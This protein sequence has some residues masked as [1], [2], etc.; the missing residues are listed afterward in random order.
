VEGCLKNNWD[1]LGIDNFAT[2]QK[3]MAD[4][5]RVKHLGGKYSF[6]EADIN[7][8]ERMIKLFVGRDV[9]FHLAALPR[10]SFSVEH[11]LEAHE[12]NATGT[13]SVLEAA[14]QAGVRR[15]IFSCSSSIFGGTKVWPTIEN[16]PM[17]PISPYALQKVVGLEYCRLY[18]ELYGIETASLIYYNVFGRLQFANSAY[19]TVIPA[20]FKAAVDGKYC[21]VDGDGLQSRDFAHVDNIVY[22]NIKAAE[23][24][25]KLMGDLFNIA[26]GETHSVLEVYEQVKLLTNTDL[27]KYHV[28]PRLGDP[29]KSH[30]DISKADVVLGYHSVTS[31]FDGLKLTAQWWLS[32]CPIKIKE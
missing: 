15:V 30:A 28:D 18:S 32:G 10:V 23:F 11:P 20:F 8:T 25:G 24:S 26:C 4:P 9:V 7:D 19:A 21:R 5:D 1:V 13:L 31:F 17:K 6:V 14:R 12:A 2:S 3:C 22:A 27:Q 16:L 29:R